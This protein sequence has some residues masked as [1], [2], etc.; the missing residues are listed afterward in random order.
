MAVYGLIGGTGLDRWGEP[1]EART[2]VTRWGEP[3][4]AL[5]R[6]PAGKDTFWSSA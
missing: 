6:Y 3:S 5:L 1:A 4:D 2:V